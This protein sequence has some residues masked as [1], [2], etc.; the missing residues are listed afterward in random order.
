[1]FNGNDGNGNGNGHDTDWSSLIDSWGAGFLSQYGYSYWSLPT[2]NNP[3]VSIIADNPQL[4][5]THECDRRFNRTSLSRLATICQ[6]IIFDAQKGPEGDGP[7]ALRRHWYQWYKT[8]LAGPLSRQYDEDSNNSKWGFNWSG[9]LSQTYAKLVDNDDV[10]YRDLWVE[11]G[12]RMIKDFIY[13][14]FANANIF[15]V[16]EKDSL[17]PDFEI[18]S[19]NLGAKVLYSGKGKSSKAAIEKV[20]REHF[21]WP[22]QS[23]WNYETN[24]YDDF[25]QAFSEEKPLIVLTISD[26]DY[27]GEAVIDPTFGEQARRYTSHV[28]EARVG[29]Q[30]AHVTQKGLDLQ[31]KWYTVKVK[32]NNKSSVA[33]ADAKA[34]YMASCSVCGKQSVVHGSDQTGNDSICHYAPFEDISPLVDLAFGFEVE[35]LPTRDYRSLLVDALLRVVPFDFIV[36]RLRI[37]TVADSDEA[38]RQILEK[39]A[40]DNPDFS[41]LRDEIARLQEQETAI[42]TEIR[43]HLDPLAREH[44]GDFADDGDD[45]VPADFVAHVENG[46]GYPWRPFDAYRRT[47]LLVDLLRDTEADA[48]ADFTSQGLEDVAHVQAR[49]L[50][51]RVLESYDDPQLL[52]DLQ[53]DINDFLAE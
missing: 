2:D 49:A 9:R 23:L 52:V 38:V 45:P 3:V 26:F 19:R 18:A 28:I 27:D 43:D 40:Q 33:W 32:A 13:R 46:Q 44:K 25:E 10:T 36:E 41:D 50:L 5:S 37:E 53:Y 35:A 14:L 11:D 16:V 1:M 12:S 20:L 51:E 7:K 42:E 8:D 39:I 21:G 22:G 17:F 4:V 6:M 34:L 47:T 48:I 15:V 30:P 24:E 31:D 29:I